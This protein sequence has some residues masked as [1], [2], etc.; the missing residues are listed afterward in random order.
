MTKEHSM[1]PL[2]V[3]LRDVTA[4]DLPIFYEHQR[5]PE[6]TA[7]AAFPARERAAFNAHW[8]HVLADADNVEQTILAAGQVAGH[9]ACFE[10]DGRREVGYWLGREFC[11]QGVATRALA[12][13]LGVVSDRPL[14]AGVAEHNVASQRVLIKC[15]FQLS[16]EHATPLLDDGVTEVLFVLDACGR[17]SAQGGRGCW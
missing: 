12:L 5:D 9:L 11:G 15:G 14:Y 6:A 17:V 7:M 3:V 10:H 13:F 2:T 4:A 8:E 16:E 1:P